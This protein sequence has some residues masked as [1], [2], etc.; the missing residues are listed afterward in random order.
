MKSYYTAV[1]TAA[2]LISG[3]SGLRA[4]DPYAGQYEVNRIDSR[5]SSY[6][7]VPGE[8]IVKF[9]ADN[10]GKSLTTNGR[11]V[12]SPKS[13]AVNSILEKYGVNKAEE[14]MPITGA[15]TVPMQKRAKAFNGEAVK[16]ADLSSLYLIQMDAAK[17]TDIHAVMEDF[18]NLDEVEYVEPNYIVHACSTTAG[19]YVSDPLYSQ[20]WGPAAIGLDKLWEVPLSSSKRPVIAILDTGVDIEHPDLTDNIWTNTLEADGVE[21]NDDDHNGFK[22]DIH[23]WDFINNS[24]KMRDNNGHG[25]HCAGIAAAVGG[26]GIGIVGANPDAL[27]MPVTILQSNGQGDIATIIK[28]IDYAVANGA[29]VISMSFGGY[30]DSMAERDALG[31]AYQKAILVAAAGNDDLCIYPHK[32]TVNKEF[33]SPM[34]PAAYNFVLGVEASSNAD[35]S[36]ATFSNFDEDG[37]I[38]STFANLENYEL[39][40]PGTGI[41]SA[42]PNGQYRQLN[43]TSMA[44]PLVSGALSR[45][46]SVKEISSKEELFGDLIASSNGN[47]NIFNAYNITDADRKPSLSLVTYRLDDAIIGDGD[48]RPDAGETIR[49]Y[50][51][52]RNNWGYAKNITYSLEVA[53]NEDPDII[54]FVD[55]SVKAV[56]NLSSYA[57]VEGENPIL[58]KINPDCVD[59]RKICLQFKANC[60]DIA[61]PLI[62][63]I[64]IDVEN[65]VEL[66]GILNKDLTLTP[67]K[68]YIITSNF[69]IPDNVTL[70]IKAGTTVKLKDDVMFNAIGHVITEGLPGNPIRFIPADNS[71]GNVRPIVFNE[72]D[73]ISYCEF[74]G[75]NFEHITGDSS[76]SG[77]FKNCMFSLNSCGYLIYHST[78]IKCNLFGNYVRTGMSA[79]NYN[80]ETVGYSNI[81]NNSHSS[82]HEEY[83]LRINEVRNNNLFNNYDRDL[84]RINSG[85]MYSKTGQIYGSNGN[86]LGSHNNGILR[87]TVY[88]IHTSGITTFG[89][90][91]LSQKTERP[92]YNAHGIVWKIVVNDYDAQDEFDLLPPLGVG[93][94]KFEVYF[95][96]HMNQER[97]PMIAMGVREPY[98]QISIAEDGSWRSETMDNGDVIDI[99]TAYLTIKGKDNFDGLNTIYVAD[100]EDEEFFPIPIEDVRF[101]V[102]VQSAGS[103]SAG[104]MAEPGVGKVTLTWDNPEE[105]FDDMLGYN[106]YRYT[107]NENDE[108]NEAVKINETLLDTEEFVD[109][110]IVP[111][112][113]YCYYYKVLRTSMDENAPSRVVSATPRAAGKG[114]ANGS[115][116]VDV[117]DV[118]T[119]VNYMVGREPKPFIFDAADVNDDREV[120]ILDVVGTVNII[121]SP[122][123]KSNVASIQSTATY[124]IEDG[125]LYVDTPVELAGI[126]VALNG[127][128]KSTEIK[129]L[130]GL[131]GMETTGEWMSD[132]EYKFISFSLSG[133]SLMPGKTALLSIG[134]AE[135]MEITLVDTNANEVMAIQ[136]GTNGIS[137]IVMAQMDVPSPNPFNESLN[138]P[139]VIGAEGNHSVELS[140]VNLA[141]VKVYSVQ[142]NLDYGKHIVT[143]TPGNIASGFYMLTLTIDGNLSQTCKV[144]KK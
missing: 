129:V 40:A 134:D 49:F 85:I 142:R 69:V 106:L 55:G 68:N 52:L 90:F 97:T 112:T 61:M 130:E 119:E 62:Q 125:I 98:T 99:Y 20:Q 72:N 60:D 79:L 36:L 92:V 22:D 94:H 82:N 74:S 54:E 87:K 117:S 2:V 1:L 27:I 141:G 109:Y 143:L 59:G 57:S 75:F 18:K 41:L 9:K 7:Y 65:G 34:Y 45:L 4:H 58:L 127:N 8:I 76:F 67:D 137:S 13:S 30:S 28:G 118:V 73:T 139:V 101:N 107:L 86:Y 63:E 21:G 136:A 110:N 135:L 50:P 108:P 83:Q 26:N 70:T 84:D 88:D 51:T 12:S 140:L 80:I 144:I 42:F 105:N 38:T 126:Q 113:T 39:R 120:D 64:V 17:M 131:K 31:K 123:S 93:K 102:N 89:E 114:D 77:I 5:K 10:S 25:T 103:M 48:G 53:E 46:I 66:G 116:N 104:F 44:C 78:L 33:G 91:D 19:D 56:S 81:A 121:M 71:L 47:L 138:I 128:R 3:S 11:R 124:S 15:A 24:A 100:A 95:S 43:G 23:G 111:G 115:G 96:K 122:S 37:S 32:C 6:E 35:G 14:L 133:K 16:D 29:D 132:D